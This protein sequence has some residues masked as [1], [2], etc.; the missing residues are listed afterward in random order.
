MFF[1]HNLTCIVHQTNCHFKTETR[2]YIYLKQLFKGW[3]F[4]RIDTQRQQGFPD[5]LILKEDRYLL[6]ECKQLKR[7]KLVSL[8]DNLTWQFGQLSFAERAFEH[9]LTYLI[10]VAKGN[11]MAFIGKAEC[12]KQIKE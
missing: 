1:G 10:T 9:R 2:S 11:E 7:K 12:L 8:E 6:L 3:K 5:C 4:N